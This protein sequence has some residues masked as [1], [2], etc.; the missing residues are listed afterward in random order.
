MTEPQAQAQPTVGIRVKLGTLITKW[1]NTL[2][3]SADHLWLLLLWAVSTPIFIKQLGAEQF[4][5]WTLINAMVNITGAMSFGFAAATVKFVAQYRARGDNEAVRQVIE[6]SAL[7]YLL[8]VCCFGGGILA[9]A[10]WISSVVFDLKGEAA[11][12]GIDA[13]RLAVVA[14]FASVF[15]QTFDAVIKGF[16]RYDISARIG[17]VTRTFILSTCMLLAIMG[18]GIPALVTTTVVGITGQAVFLFYIARTRFVP[19]LRPLGLAPRG[20]FRE[21]MRFGLQAWIQE[22]AGALSNVFDRFLVGALVSPAA[23]G[24]YALC[25][26]LAQ[27]MHLLLFRALAWM[28]PA[29]SHET[30]NEQNLPALLRIYRIGTLIA[31]GMVAALAI[32]MYSLAPQILTAWVGEEI[33]KEGGPILRGL[34]IYFSIL[35]LGTPISFLVNGTGFPKWT[36]AFALCQG[37]LVLGLAAWLL[38]RTGLE[39]I[40][41]A[42]LLALP[43]L[44]ILFFALHF[45]VLPGASIVPTVKFITILISTVLVLS[46]AARVL[47]SDLV[48][49]TLWAVIPSGLA[50]TAF[51]ALV[52]Y[53]PVRFLRKREGEEQV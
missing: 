36:T 49:P 47:V 34:V 10:P 7:M 53:I 22:L 21:V 42:R 26:Q 18:A 12:L 30:A 50:L 45:R 6:V 44:G 9:A 5:I 27:Q 32:P 4:G 41:D 38:P 14:L 20:L 15:W 11:S 39:G 25:L 28:V 2:F 24:V 23:A 8:S 3:S 37:A 16:E 1:R 31:L 52:V 51:G 43:S 46:F 17:M 19:G 33:A 48:P 40:V 13:L 29:A 35:C